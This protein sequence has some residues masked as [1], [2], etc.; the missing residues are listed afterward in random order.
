MP[1]CSADDVAGALRSR[2]PDLRR[3]QLG[4]FVAAVR[5]ALLSSMP[6]PAEAF[7]ADS[8]VDSRASSPSSSRRQR[9]RLSHDA[10]SSTSFSGDDDD[11]GARPPS[12][13][14]AFDVTKSML[15]ARYASLT[16]KKDPGTNQ[17]LEIE[18]NAEKPRRRMTADGGAGGDS[19]LEAAAVAPAT[20][21][22]GGRVGKGPMFS[23]LGGMKTVIDELMMEVVVPLC[24]PQLPLRL[25]VR[26]VAGILLHGPPGCGKTTLAHAIANETGVP[27]YKISAP[28]I[29][30]GVSG[31]SEENIRIL[32][33][34]AYRTAPSIV[35]IDEIDAIAS[36]REN[37]QREME[38]RIVTQ[39][40]TCMDE[41]HQNVGSDGS[42]LD[43][44][45]SEKKPGYV[46]VIGAT[47]RP[48]AVDQALR[49]PGRFDREISLGVPDET[50]RQQILKML[51]KNLTLE[52]EGHFDLFKIARATPGYVGADLKALVDKA[53]NLAMKRII[54]ARKKLLGDDENNE[55]DWWRLPW[56]ESEMEN[57]CIAMDDFE[58]AVTMVQ[59]SLRRE[60]F[61]SVPD[62]TWEDVGGLDS[63][64]K[65]FY[66]CIVRCIKY[67]EDYKE[68]GVNMQA[69]FLL[70]GPPGCGK[71][72]IAKAVAHDAG[73]SFIHIKGPELLN[74]YVGES[75]SEVRKIFTRAR[76]NSPCILFFDEIDAL[77][78]KRGKEG[79][80]VVER[81]LNQLLIELDGA[82]QRH[83]VYVIGATNRIDVIDEAVLRPGRFGKKHFVPLPGADERVSILKAHAKDKPVSADVD[84]DTLARRQ[85]CN[86]L[87]G[88]DLASLVN[89]AAMAALGEK[90]EFLENGTASRSLSFTR[91]IELL[92]F[93]HALS[94]VKPSVS[95]QQRKHFDMLSKKYSAD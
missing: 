22:G 26:P 74:K 45:S 35:F 95:E 27:F 46:I 25:G 89:E 39:L 83:G 87:S 62:V 28:E 32:F 21:E 56:N 85:E 67:P 19:K 47:N 86:N 30:S 23:D 78:T 34:K 54:I 38:R 72:L 80:W 59:P 40:M 12:P 55:Q 9:R 20:T 37:L 15:R 52:A 16:P 73:A 10:S 53:G 63:L 91:E 65:E 2:N 93:E 3:K 69:G 41:F 82:D 71:T 90:I 4:P 1:G 29:V 58:N 11:G 92:H 24:H 84:L 75:E 44:Q 18:V 64:R 17:Q 8:D 77:T 81:L 49:R 94:K 57:L 5:R 43:S 70:F 66:R 13:P 42:D 14:P 50:A 48:D 60:G 31:A 51:T 7:S 36:K 61:S 76:T 79:G 33:Q 6:A 88:A 68:Y